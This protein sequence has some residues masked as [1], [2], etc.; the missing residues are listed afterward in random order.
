M[1]KF[2]WT[3]L[4]AWMILIFAFSSQPAAVSNEKSRLVVYFL[5]LLGL[6]LNSAFGTMAD[7]VVRKA[8]H[9]SEYFILYLLIYNVV[10]DRYKGL[11][12][13][14]VSLLGVFIYACSDEIHQLFVPGRAG[15]ITD[16]LI[17]TAGG[18]LAMGA[19]YLSSLKK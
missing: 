6:D 5:N 7:Y 9:F 1:K 17:D 11:K 14:F 10:R 12:A 15:R 18:A 8:A 2:K 13:L 4:I 3:L 19:A 16:V